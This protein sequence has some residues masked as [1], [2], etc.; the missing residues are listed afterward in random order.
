M[1]SLSHFLATL[2]CIGVAV[3]DFQL[4]NFTTTSTNLTSICVDILNLPIACDPA[5]EWAGQGRFEDD[6]T[7]S[8]VCTAESTYALDT[9]LGRATKACK[10][11]YIDRLGNA[12]LPAYYVES[13]RENYNVS[14]LKNGYVLS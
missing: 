2:S 7:L 4:Y 13:V 8:L 5:L 9:W 12:I 1:V 6:E 3:A 11:R 10:D 14:C